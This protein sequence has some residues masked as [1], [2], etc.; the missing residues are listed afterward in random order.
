MSLLFSSTSVIDSGS[1]GILL[2]L[3]AFGQFVCFG[4]YQL[5]ASDH[6]HRRIRDFNTYQ[7]SFHCSHLSIS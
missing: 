1:F 5:E 4:A 3:L 6:D 7:M 2:Q